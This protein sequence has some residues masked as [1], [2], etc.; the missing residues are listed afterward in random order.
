MIKFKRMDTD[1]IHISEV[2]DLVQTQFEKEMLGDDSISK[3]MWTAAVQSPDNLYFDVYEE[4]KF[5]GYVAFLPYT[6]WS[7][8]VHA[9]FI[10]LRTRGREEQ[11]SKLAKWV[12]KDKQLH[13]LRAFVPSPRRTTSALLRRMEWS[14]DGIL[15]A[16]VRKS[17]QFIDCN[18]FS[19]ED[20]GVSNG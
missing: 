1:Y 13:I 20:K 6:D 2:W 11:L 12:M 16:A 10:D 15:R 14:E 8:V 19:L 3:E 9:L 17:G 4:D 7:M 5:V 18:V